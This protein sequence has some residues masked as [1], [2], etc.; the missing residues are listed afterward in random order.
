M[1]TQM[2]MN[3]CNIKINSLKEGGLQNPLWFT[4][5][6]TMN[7]RK[8]QKFSLTKENNNMGSSWFKKKKNGY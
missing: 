2:L 3:I 8:K 4:M 5:Q 7:W 6:M 1:T